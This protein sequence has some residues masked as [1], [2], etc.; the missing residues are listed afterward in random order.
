M[1]EK[2][3]TE[4]ESLFELSMVKHPKQYFKNIVSRNLEIWTQKPIVS[5]LWEYENDDDESKR[6]INY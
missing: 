6:I 1:W 2:K 3:N 5:Y 4:P